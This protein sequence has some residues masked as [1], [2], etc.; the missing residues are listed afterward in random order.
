MARAVTPA[1][2]T[3]ITL[4]AWTCGLLIFFPSFLLGL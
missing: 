4:A 3:I 2:K 1:R